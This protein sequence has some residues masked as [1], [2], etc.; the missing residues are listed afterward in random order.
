M[1]FDRLANFWCRIGRGRWGPWRRETPVQWT[2]QWTHVNVAK[3]D[4]RDIIS[5][6][7]ERC[8]IYCLGY[9]GVVLCRHKV[10]QRTVRM[11]KSLVQDSVASARVWVVRRL[12]RGEWKQ[13]ASTDH[14]R[15]HDNGISGQLCCGAH[16]YGKLVR[17]DDRPLS[18]ALVKTVIH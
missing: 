1:D 7:L 17:Q 13:E 3:E 8:R 12:L 18:A 10:R 15:L 4:L 11:H 9:R 6:C 2:R 5:Q 14:I 16:N